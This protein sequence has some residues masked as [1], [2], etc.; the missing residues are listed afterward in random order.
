MFLEVGDKVPLIELIKGAA[1]VSANDSALAI[2]EF[3]A[4][5]EEAFVERMNETAHA[6]GMSD[7]HFV[8][9]HGLPREGQYTSAAGM[10]VLGFRYLNDHPEALKF[11]SLP[12]FAYGGIKQK[13]WNALLRRGRGVTGLK[14][15]YLRISGYHVLFSAQENDQTLVGAVLGGAT[16]ET[17]NQDARELLA[18]GFDNFSTRAAVTEGEVVGTVDVPN[19]EPGNLRLAAAANVVVTVRKDRTDPVPLR[20]EIPTTVKAP[21]SE[22]S[23][24][25]KL[26]LEGEGFPRREIDLVAN[27]EIAVKSYGRYYGIG[28]AVAVSLLGVVL[29]GQVVSGKKR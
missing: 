20:K 29:V 2:A 22:G 1:V 19:G 17:R 25:G 28:F 15:G 7:T 26:V 3:L 4:G 13:N 14:T 16:P 6:L 27:Q 23:T 24:V 8:N 10:A 5:S 9:P 21:I 11:H 18:Y 12:T